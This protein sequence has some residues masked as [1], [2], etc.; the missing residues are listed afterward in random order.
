M[1]ARVLEDRV[2]C[3]VWL[4]LPKLA[5]FPSGAQDIASIDGKFAN[6]VGFLISVDSTRKK[7]GSYK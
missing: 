7:R 3:A 2:V 4:A 1:V 5:C 6:S